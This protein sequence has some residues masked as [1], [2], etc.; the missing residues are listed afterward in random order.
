MKVEVVA[1]GACQLGHSDVFGRVGAYDADCLSEDDGHVRLRQALRVGN[2]EVAG[3]EMDG[4]DEA[5]EVET[6][7]DSHG[8]MGDGN[9]NRAVCVGAGRESVRELSISLTPGGATSS[10]V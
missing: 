4:A 1:A 3:D 6:G 10:T 7:E 2:E 8:D 9:G 5:D